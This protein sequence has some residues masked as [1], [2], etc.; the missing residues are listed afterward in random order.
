[1]NA[2]FNEFAQLGI[3]GARVD[4]IAAAA[5]SNKAQIY[6]YFGSKDAL[7]DAVMTQV[8]DRIMAKTPIDT[9]DLP[10]YAGRLFDEYLAAPEI[11]RLVT[12]QRLERGGREPLVHA[13][14]D[15]NADKVAAIE[16]AQRQGL[17]STAHEPETLLVLVLH[18]AAMW[19]SQSLEYQALTEH[20]TDVQRRQIVVDATRSITAP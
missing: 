4:R 18:L 13:V 15:S 10:E 11:A 7:F 3:A 2:A 16:K 17:V 8:V 1:M 14:V 20:L 12:W 6:Y 5:G 9:T 19:I